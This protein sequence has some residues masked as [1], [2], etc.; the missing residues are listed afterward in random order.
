[1]KLQA[2][3]RWSKA[4]G[5]VKYMAE[6]SYDFITVCHPVKFGCHRHKVVEIYGFRLSRD[7]EIPHDQRVKWLY[8]LEV[9]ILCYHPT[10][11][12][13][14][15]H[16]VGGNVSCGWKATFNMLAYISH[17]YLSLKHMACHAYY[18]PTAPRATTN[19]TYEK[20]FVSPFKNIEEKKKG[21]HEVFWVTHKSINLT[22][23][24]E[25]IN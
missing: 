5:G 16:Y 14:H 8:R 25:L 11:V 13:G 2:V 9:L 17:C 4:T 23:L 12:G 18:W 1:M 21:N 24:N 19:K 3:G 10:K 15:Q 7:L 20:C 22:N 6:G